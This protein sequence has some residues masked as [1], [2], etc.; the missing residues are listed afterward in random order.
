MSKFRAEEIIGYTYIDGRKV[1]VLKMGVTRRRYYDHIDPTSLERHINDE[2]IAIQRWTDYY[3]KV[4]GVEDF[5][6][7]SYN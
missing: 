7:E 4:V 5:T 3:R 6:D 2:L 1:T